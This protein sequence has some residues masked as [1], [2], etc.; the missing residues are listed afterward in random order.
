MA[1]VAMRATLLLNI[2]SVRMKSALAPPLTALPMAPS[3]SFADFAATDWKVHPDERAPNS[4]SFKLRAW[5]R[6]LGF[7]RAVTWDAFGKISLISFNR[8]P[9]K[10][11][12]MRATPVTF[13]PGYMKLLISPAST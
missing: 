11:A 4:A 2:E 3:N 9:K 12:D 13:P 6:L 8:S 10:S 1:R 7:D 5:P